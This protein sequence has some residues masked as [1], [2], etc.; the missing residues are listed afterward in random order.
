MRVSATSLLR[1]CPLDK[2]EGVVKRHSTYP[3]IRFGS[4]ARSPVFV[5]DESHRR[6]RSA[7]PRHRLGTGRHITEG[8][9]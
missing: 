4:T 5:K 8:C 3:P 2:V 9:S 6:S 1:W 7:G